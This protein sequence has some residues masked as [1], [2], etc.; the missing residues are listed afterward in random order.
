MVNTG[1]LLI[2]RSLA[3][4]IRS[5]FE[6]SLDADDISLELC[7]PKYDAHYTSAIALA[8]KHRIANGESFQPNQIAEAIAN[9]IAQNQEIVTHYQ[10]QAIGKGWLNIL[11]NDEYLGLS[12]QALETLRIQDLVNVDGCWQ[13]VK[14]MAEV[15]NTN[16]SSELIGQYVYARCCSL[17]R[18]AQREHEF[19]TNNT[20]DLKTSLQTVEISLLLHNLAIADHLSCEL[21]C[22][23]TKNISKVRSGLARSLAELFLDFYDHCQIFGVSSDIAYRRIVL[24]RVSQKLLL[25]ITPSEFNYSMSL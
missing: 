10:V 13:R 15:K 2:R 8:I 5:L 1:L 11:L 18:L 22:L 3:A 14:T 16:S 19:S 7:Y 4:A 21:S 12:F 9:W 24:I 20:L 6:I 25:A 17:I 23:N